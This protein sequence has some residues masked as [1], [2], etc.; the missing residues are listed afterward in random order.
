MHYTKITSLL[1]VSLFGIGSVAHAAMEGSAQVVSDSSASA[2]STEVQIHTEVRTEVNTREETNAAQ[3]DETAED[4]AR[5]SQTMESET[6]SS[7]EDDR[8]NDT[9]VMQHN[10]SD[11]EFLKGTA[12]SVTA[13]EVR[14]WDPKQKQ[15]FLATVKTHAEVQSEQELEN[16]AKGVL[17]EDANVRSIAVEETGVRLVYQMPAKFLGVFTTSLNT[18]VDA[19]IDGKVNVRYPW[20]SFIFKKS[21]SASDLETEV[22]TALPEVDDEVIVGFEHSAEILLKIS[23]SLKARHDV[24]MN[25][26]RN[27]K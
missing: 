15:E 1:I 6:K 27:I 24:A 20:Y 3:E 8:E 16:F 7:D 5:S 13:V 18:H 10:Q 21:V 22:T 14:G 26:I 23:T 4:G 17:L 2:S 9:V 19:T 11:L 25:S 12:V